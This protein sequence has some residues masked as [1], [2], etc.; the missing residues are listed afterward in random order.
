M[1]TIIIALATYALTIAVGT[2]IAKQ[3]IIE[4]EALQ[5][6]PYSIEVIDRRAR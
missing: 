4:R 2:P 3:R 5:I 1:P 6:I